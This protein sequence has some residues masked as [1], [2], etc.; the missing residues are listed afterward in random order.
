MNHLYTA[1][2][3][4][5][6]IF[7]KTDWIGW[8]P[9]GRA[10]KSQEEVTWLEFPFP[11]WTFRIWKHGLMWNRQQFALSCMNWGDWVFL[12]L[13]REWFYQWS[14]ISTDRLPYKITASME[15]SF[16]LPRVIRTPT[17]KVSSCNMPEQ[18]PMPRQHL[19]T[20]HGWWTHAQ[21]TEPMPEQHGVVWAWVSPVPSQHWVKP[22]N[23]SLVVPGGNW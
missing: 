22:P 18:H 20:G 13:T 15:S 23:A 7:L 19:L 5:R 11:K 21:A 6:L 1:I 4:I 14:I 16:S 8:S 2:C 3:L 17:N 12:W 10:L 9:P